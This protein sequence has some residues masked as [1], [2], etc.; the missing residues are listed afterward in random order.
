MSVRYKAAPDYIH[1]KIADVNVLVPIGAGVADF[2]GYI[3][4]NASASVLW[5]SLKEPHTL[6][7]LVQLMEDAFS[8]DRAVAAEDVEEF[9]E[10]LKKHGML[11][12][13]E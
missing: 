8:I 12:V 1:R 3:E 7:E 9:L 4:L 11:A 10:L 5:D 13:I 6:D 2:N